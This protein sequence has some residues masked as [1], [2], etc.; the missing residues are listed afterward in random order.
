MLSQ[1]FGVPPTTL[2]DRILR[3]ATGGP[4]SESSLADA[5]SSAVT[6][7]TSSTMMH[8]RR[9]AEKLY[10]MG[11]PR[12]ATGDDGDA[13][14][15]DIPRDTHRLRFAHAGY[16]VRSALADPGVVF[17]LEHLRRPPRS[18]RRRRRPRKTKA[19]LRLL[20]E[21]LRVNSRREIRPTSEPRD[22]SCSGSRTVSPTFSD[23]CTGRTDQRYPGR[24]ERPRR[25]MSRRRLA[26]HS[27]LELRLKV[28][29][30]GLVFDLGEPAV[31]AMPSVI[32]RKI[33]QFIK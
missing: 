24:C 10:V 32:L 3:T 21:E 25:R 23:I 29:P 6:T 22:R 14:F 16:E 11:Q 13:S 31:C 19:L 7:G 26:L 33:L 4:R 20:I 28:S 8:A 27:P 17:P 30:Y 5:R 12:F 15:R 1:Y 18:S 2:R 9:G